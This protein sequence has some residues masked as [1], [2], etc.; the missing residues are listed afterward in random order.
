MTTLASRT[1]RAVALAATVLSVPLSARSRSASD[2]ATQLRP[3]DRRVAQ[4][5]H[6][7]RARSRTIALL[8]ADV[9]RTDVVVYIRA[10]PRRPGDLAGSTGFMGVGADGR[11][12]LMVT[13]YGDTGWTTLEDAEDRQLITLGH[14]LRHVLEVAA[15][16]GITSPE[17]FAAFYRAI[18]HEWKPAHVDTADARHAGLRVAAELATSPE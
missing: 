9:E 13:L 17:A 11:R 5:V 4:L 6:K 2:E 15:E 1:V 3:M 7:G 8:M 18:G 12:W 16:P 10:T 14:E